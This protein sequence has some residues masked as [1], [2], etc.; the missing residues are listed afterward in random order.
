MFMGGMD[1]CPLPHLCMEE[2]WWGLPLTCHHGCT[3]LNPPGNWNISPKASP[4]P[5]MGL[6]PL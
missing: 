2:G 4:V 3:S 5:E 6:P 1:R